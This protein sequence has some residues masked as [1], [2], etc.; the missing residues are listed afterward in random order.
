VDQEKTEIEQFVVKSRP[1][2]ILHHFVPFP[3]KAA[4]RTPVRNSVFQAETV[5]G[6]S[7]NLDNRRNFGMV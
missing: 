4:A 2:A 6:T 1:A 7:E 5:S 3:Q